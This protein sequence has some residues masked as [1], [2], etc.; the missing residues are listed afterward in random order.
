M[1]GSCYV[2]RAHSCWNLFCEYHLS[3]WLASLE[4]VKADILG[5]GGISLDEEKEA[6]KETYKTDFIRRVQAEELNHGNNQEELTRA[7]QS[8][9]L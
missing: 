9:D 4:Y 7:K 6:R 5:L 1:G 2:C 3:L 8:E